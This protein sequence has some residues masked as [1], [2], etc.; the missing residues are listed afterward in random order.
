MKQLS[1]AGLDAP[2]SP[3]DRLVLALFPDPTIT[4]ELAGLGSFLRDKNGL[5]CK[6]IAPDRLHVTLCLIGDFHSVPPRV[7]TTVNE[8]LK[9]FR[10]SSFEVEFDRARSFQGSG[11][12]VVTGGKGVISLS[13]FRQSLFTTLKMAGLQMHSG[14]NF[15][16][17]I[18]LFY[19]N[20]IIVAE[21]AVEPVRWKVQEF[22]LI[23]SLLRQTQYIRLARWPLVGQNPDAVVD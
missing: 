1:L 10:A 20:Q 18:T 15:T 8:A 21:H 2:I 19:D 17:H 23:H 11:A 12:F 5:I 4:N 7:L 14:S 6:Q 22:V 3:T 13:T 16:P 9:N